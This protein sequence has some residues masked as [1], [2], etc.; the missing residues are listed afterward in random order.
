MK[1]RAPK[2]VPFAFAVTMLSGIGG[3]GAIAVVIITIIR[4]FHVV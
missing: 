4:M 3:G 2:S 1:L